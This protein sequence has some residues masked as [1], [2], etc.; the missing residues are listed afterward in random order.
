MLKPEFATA[1]FNLG[2]VNLSLK[3]RDAALKQY[4]VLKT[5]DRNLADKLYGMIY[6]AKIF[7]VSEAGFA[8]TSGQRN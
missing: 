6:Q 4:A 7:Q 2:V 1:F 5:L 8:A 3:D